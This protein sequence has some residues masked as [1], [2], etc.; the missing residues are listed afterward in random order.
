MSLI[1]DIKRD[2]EAGTPGPWRTGVWQGDDWP[3]KRWSVYKHPEGAAVCISP[4]Y[5]DH[6]DLTDARRIARVPD[7]EERIL[8]DAAYI[9]ALEAQLAE[10][11][12]ALRPSADTKAAYMG[13][14]RVPL[15]D[16]D[17]DGSEVMRQINVPWV[18][19]K[20][21]M[22]AIRNRSKLEALK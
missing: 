5:A 12:E 7:M 3:E 16:Y 19:I 20:E 17:E 2:R 10:A 1:D 13:E 11:K 9:T 15:P 18:T 22:A 14:F 6:E 4:R 8:S 21:I